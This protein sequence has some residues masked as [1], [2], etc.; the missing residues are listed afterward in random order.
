MASNPGI[1]RWC[2][3]AGG[4]LVF[5]KGAHFLAQAGGGGGRSRGK[6]HQIDDIL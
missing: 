1:A 2:E 6:R 3:L 5:Q 4:D